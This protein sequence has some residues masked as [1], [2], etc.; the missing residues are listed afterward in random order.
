MQD[1]KGYL[2]EEGK[3]LFCVLRLLWNPVDAGT[4]LHMTAMEGEREDQ[5]EQEKDEME[6]EG[7]E[8]LCGLEE[9][10]TR[11]GDDRGSSFSG[12]KVQY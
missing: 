11:V 5:R 4:G 9:S 3:S 10:Q 8:Y 1:N 12:V 2:F 7:V 6:C